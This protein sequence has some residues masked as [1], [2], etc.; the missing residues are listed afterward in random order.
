MR[1]LMFR[2]VS[3]FRCQESKNRTNREW[4]S[5]SDKEMP[6]KWPETGLQSILLSNI[7]QYTQ[8][9]ISRV[10]SALK[11][12]FRLSGKPTDGPA[13]KHAQIIS[14]NRTQAKTDNGAQG[15]N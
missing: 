5:N 13:R 6:F 7:G 8:K 10:R 15:R 12:V 11:C 14:S 3:R 1:N 9:A 2:C 4:I